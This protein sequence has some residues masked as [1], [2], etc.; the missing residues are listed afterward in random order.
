MWQKRYSIAAHYA[1]LN[2]Q[3][4]EF[5][6][7]GK[8]GLHYYLAVSTFALLDAHQT[9][10]CLQL[11]KTALVLKEGKSITSH[12]QTQDLEFVQ[13]AKK[14]PKYGFEIPNDVLKYCDQM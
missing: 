14:P 5:R 4:Q 9:N 13:L 6:N 12:R 11:G 1:K 2:L 8:F 7:L 3:Q 10:D